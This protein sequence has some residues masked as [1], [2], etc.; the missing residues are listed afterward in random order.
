ML[1]EVPEMAFLNPKTFQGFFC[2]DSFCVYLGNLC[3][4]QFFFPAELPLNNV[5]QMK[6]STKQVVDYKVQGFSLEFLVSFLETRAFS[7]AY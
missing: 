7:L 2:C 6:L 5:F 3:I 4:E 1:L